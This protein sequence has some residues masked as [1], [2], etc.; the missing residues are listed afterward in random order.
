MRKLNCEGHAELKGVW[1]DVHPSEPLLR[2]ARLEL[3]CVARGGARKGWF[4]SRASAAAGLESHCKK[5]K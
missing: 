1:V 4:T 2:C 3:K 5:Y